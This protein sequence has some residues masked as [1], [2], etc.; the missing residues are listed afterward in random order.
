M[1]DS[2]AARGGGM[3]DE[4]RFFRSWFTNPLVTGAVSPSGRALAR[5]MAGFVEADKDG[6]IIELGPGTGVVT[7]ALI[8]RGI[9]PERIVAVEYSVDFCKLLSERYPDISI[10]RGD[11][12]SIAETLEGHIDRPP[13]AVVS[14]LPLLTR[15]VSDRTSLLA[16][17]FEMMRPGAPFIQFTYGVTPPIPREPSAAEIDETG[18][19][20]W[21]LP[22]AKVFV[23]RRPQAN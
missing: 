1:Q 5:R 22:P 20:W 3:G 11:A 14:S 16:A 6:P 9:A 12:Y 2:K 4:L 23:Y 17:C 7:R 15:P 18:R 21:N 8:E 13:V 19:I 10:V